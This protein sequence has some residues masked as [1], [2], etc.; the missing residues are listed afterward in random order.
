M[1]FSKHFTRVP[2]NT[3]RVTRPQIVRPIHV[4]MLEVF[5]EPKDFITKITEPR[6]IIQI[7]YPSTP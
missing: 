5:K 4:W 1:F 3:W 2:P 7:R 6:E